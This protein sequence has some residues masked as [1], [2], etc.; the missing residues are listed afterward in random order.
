MPRRERRWPRLS[1]RRRGFDSKSKTSHGGG[2]VATARPGHNRDM[3]AERTDLG[4]LAEELR[5]QAKEL[6][7]KANKL[8]TEPEEEDRVIKQLDEAISTFDEIA[9]ANR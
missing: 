9:K 4:R 3:A 7:E 8:E 2:V 5:Q 1:R 6:R